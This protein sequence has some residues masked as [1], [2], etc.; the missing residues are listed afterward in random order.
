MD[1]E[2]AKQ[3]FTGLPTAR[4]VVAFDPKKGRSCT[5]DTFRVDLTDTPRSPWNLSAAQVFADDFCAAH[6]NLRRTRQEVLDAWF[7]HFDNLRANYRKQEASKKELQA[8]ENARTQRRRTERRSNLY[9]RRYEAAEYYLSIR[10]SA[11][12]LIKMLGADGMS[13]DESGHEGQQGEAIYFVT[14]KPWRA[15]KLTTWLRTLDSLHLYFRY[16]GK[17]KATSG[18]W[19]HIRVTS[20]VSSERAAVPGLPENFYS[21]TWLETLSE[22]E[23]TDLQ[24]EAPMQ[25]PDIPDE[26]VKYVV[27]RLLVSYFLT[28]F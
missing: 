1:R 25:I 16:Q 4:E 5:A 23:T 12:P 8:L 13:S 17:W 22:F 19:P 21:A 18:A 10:Q 6:P 15:Q 3:P 11:L 9:S 26:L 7:T 28:H 14:H 24:P 20:T 27:Q 2:N